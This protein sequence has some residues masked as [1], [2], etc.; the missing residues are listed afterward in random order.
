MTVQPQPRF[1]PVDIAVVV[2]MN[3]MWGLNMIAVKMS[4][5]LVQ[6]MTAAFL[7]QLLVMIICLPA[8]R[9]MPGR[10]RLLLSLGALS[11]GLFYIVNN[12]ALSVSDN[13]SA[14]AIASQLGGPFTLILAIVY[15]KEK[16]RMFRIVGMALSFLGVAIIAFDP[17]IAKEQLGVA[18]MT[19]VG[20]IWAVCAMIQRKLV[21]TPVLTMFAWI[22]FIGAAVLLPI[23]YFAE[24]DGFAAIPAIPLTTWGWIAFSA[25]GS[26]LIGQGAMSWL[27]QR[28]EVSAVV[29]LTLAA[30]VIAVIA[31]WAYFDTAFTPIMV[32]GGIIALSGVAIVT[33]RTARVGGLK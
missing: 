7:R 23:S 10:M 14:L 18:L 3:L 22:G 2:I 5:D 12:L 32:F 15:L 26:T 13:V 16:V 8:L 24:P 28:H 19:C 17:A 1:G 31:G 20:L 11:G 30:P 25:I 21:G 33:I 29:P 6:P 9:I 4:V 27:I